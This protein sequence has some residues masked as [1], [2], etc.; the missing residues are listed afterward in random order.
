MDTKP[1][2]Q[3]VNFSG[4]WVKG[5]K[6]DQGNPVPLAH[7]NAR[8]AVALRALSN[9]DPEL[10]NP[11]GVPLDGIVYGGRDAHAYF[12]VQQ[13]YDWD[14]GIIAYGAALETETTFATVGEEG[15]PEINV[16]SIQDFVSIPL[17][18]YIQNNLDFGRSLRR[19]PLVF[20]VNYFL[21]DEAGKFVNAVRDKAVW[22][23]WMELRVHGDT[24]AI[25]TATGQIPHY[26]DLK[27]LFRQV[28]DKDYTE[29]DYSEQFTLRVV[30][31]LA[32]IDRVRKYYQDG[33]AH[34]PTKL[35]EV[36]ESQRRRL[37]EARKTFGDYASPFDLAEQAEQTSEQQQ[38]DLADEPSA[39]VRDQR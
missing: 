11:Q 9:C 4:H 5:K 13:S 7:K 34:P 12:P 8:Y 31:N 10:D 18:K 2:S 26:E 29:E 21:R 17:G 14:H 30:E 1:P 35:F 24:G 27:R 19:T 28:L 15:V 38:S 25:P 3:G 22:V 33:V 16:M 32:K 23:K 36:L 37:A 6:D 39:G 20:G